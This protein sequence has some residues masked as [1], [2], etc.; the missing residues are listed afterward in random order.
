MEEANGRNHRKNK[1]GG[2]PLQGR[3]ICIRVM[4]L[5]RKEKYNTDG[6]VIT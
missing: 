4:M 3:Q 1:R 2:F 6:Q 5:H